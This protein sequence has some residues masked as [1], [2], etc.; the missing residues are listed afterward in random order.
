LEE[1]EIW[2]DMTAHLIGE[3]DLIRKVQEYT[4]RAER[5]A[6]ELDYNLIHAHDWLTYP[7]GMLAKKISQKP[8]VVHIHATEFDRAGGPGDERVHKI[9]HAGMIYAD[10][11]IAV[12]QYTAQMIMSRYRIDTAKIRI[13]HNAFSLAEDAV[14]AKKRIFKGPTVLFLGRITL[15]KGP[16][17]FLDVADRVLK[18]HPE[19]RFIMAGTGDMA[20][21]LLRQSASK[22]LQNKFLFTGFLN[23]GQVE[24]ILRASDIYVLPS[25]SEPFGISPLE[26][27]AFGIT[28]IIS[29]Q[30]GV[31]EVVN[32]AFK[33]DYWDIDLMADT[34]NHLIENPERCSKVGLEGMREVNKIHWNEAADKIRGIYSH[35]LAEFIKQN[36]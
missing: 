16:D 7:S 3:E 15:Q 13:V 20:R 12:S 2:E 23:R 10:L 34:I 30:S 26:A 6:R 35:V 21:Q 31:A 17:Y 24:D 19:A 33:I 18:V 36:P 4:L 5:F 27:M 9:E 29:K 1:R 22:R 25:V 14:P 11:V 32:N 28:S 8:L